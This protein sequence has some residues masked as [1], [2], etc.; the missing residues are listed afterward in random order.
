MKFSATCTRV[1]DALL[2]GR[3]DGKKHAKNF[4]KR[5]LWLMKFLSVLLI[6]YLSE[7]E[8]KTK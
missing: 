2:N 7:Q 4:I 1:T 8:W 3:A 6:A 5:Y